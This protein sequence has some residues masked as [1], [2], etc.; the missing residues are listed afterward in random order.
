MEANNVSVIPNHASTSC[1]QHVLRL[2]VVIIFAIG[3]AYTPH[4]ITGLSTAI[5][6]EQL[7]LL[8]LKNRGEPAARGGMDRRRHVVGDVRPDPQGQPS[9]GLLCK[10]SVHGLVRQKAVGL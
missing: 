10:G 1:V 3:M 7:P 6:P 5:R 9:P 2:D 4:Y 8:P